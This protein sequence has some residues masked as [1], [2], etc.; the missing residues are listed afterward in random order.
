MHHLYVFY[1]LSARFYPILIILI[2][3]K[4]FNNILKNVYYFLG[5]H[6]ILPPRTFL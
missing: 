6:I 5:F 1:R 4:G 2:P 3:S